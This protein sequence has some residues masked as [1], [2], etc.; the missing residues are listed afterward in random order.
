[1]LFAITENQN[2]VHSGIKADPLATMAPR[3]A[4][5]LENTSD[6]DE[7]SVDGN[8]SSP[9]NIPSSSGSRNTKDDLNPIAKKE[10]KQI[11]WLRAVLVSVLFLATFAAAFV[12]YRVSRN[13][14]FHEFQSAYHDS[15]IK[16]IDSFD[17]NL[18]N[19]IG[20]MDNFAIVT[21]TQA[22][23]ENW[24]FVV[25]PKFE[26]LGASTRNLAGAGVL[27]VIPLV[28]EEDRIAWE[29]YSL[30]NSGWVEDGLR[31]NETD[32][33][34]AEGHEH[35]RELQTEER[36]EDH[37]EDP[38]DEG[39]VDIVANFSKGIANAIFRINEHTHDDTVDDTGGPY[40]P[41]WQTTPATHEEMVNYNLRSHGSF[42]K[43][44]E[45]AVKSVEIVFGR[46]AD[47]SDIHNPF[48]FLDHSPDIRRGRPRR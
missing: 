37:D 16:I 34:E 48:N 38:E 17:A 6:N 19:T 35:R 31:F 25:A 3:S 13:G 40:W 33:L 28:T 1:L 8:S 45:E 47:V 14:E 21:S 41:I 30:K 9:S 44:L 22:V 20:A 42:G 12:I 5:A 26:I 18:R 2:Y 10:S 27:S 11:Y 4:L 43:D 23:D 36:D 32:H 15:A 24:P 46:V 29:E 39:D 7:N